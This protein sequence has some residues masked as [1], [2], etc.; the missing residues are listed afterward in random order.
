MHIQPVC[1][2]LYI[3]AIEQVALFVF[4]LFVVVTMTFPTQSV[5]KK[6]GYDRICT[7]INSKTNPRYPGY[8]YRICIIMYVMNSLG[9]EDE[10][11]CTGLNSDSFPKLFHFLFTMYMDL[12]ALS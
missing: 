3:L 5:Q 8:S 4:L 6:A 11:N 1:T 9:T 12:T 10:Q 2:I 7:L